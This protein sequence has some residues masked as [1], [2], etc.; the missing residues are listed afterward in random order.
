MN[1]PLEGTLQSGFSVV[2]AVFLLLRIEKELKHLTRAIEQLRHCQT[3]KNRPV[4]KER[5]A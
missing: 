4:E 5:I 2:V 3:C 1:I